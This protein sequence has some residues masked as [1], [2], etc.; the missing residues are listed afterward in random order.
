MSVERRHAPRLEVLDQLHGRL[1]SLNVS[2][3]VRELGAGGFSVESTVPFPPGARHRFR[4]RIAGGGEV[5]VDAVGVHSRSIRASDDEDRYIT[6]F[7]FCQDG[8]P[9]AARAVATLL[10][11]MNSVLEFR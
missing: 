10:N 1:V 2:L 9:E 5:I 11:A 3:V 8:N 7:A 6:G 4:F